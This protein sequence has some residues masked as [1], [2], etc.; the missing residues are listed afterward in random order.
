M[1][2]CWP[3]MGR[4]FSKRP[5]LP[6]GV[7]ILFGSCLSRIQTEREPEHEYPHC[8]QLYKVNFSRYAEVQA[9]S[10]RSS[11]PVAGRRTIPDGRS[12]GDYK[13]APARSL[14][15][16]ESVAARGSAQTD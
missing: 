15:P 7:R 12:Q 2:M 3:P 13:T 6:Y 9:L 4:L 14:R 11:R 16:D 5:F 10:H 8:I 1:L